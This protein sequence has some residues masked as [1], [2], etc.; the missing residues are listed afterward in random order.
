M[1]ASIPYEVFSE[2]VEK[3]ERQGKEIENVQEAENVQSVWVTGGALSLTCKAWSQLGQKLY[4]RNRVGG[5]DPIRF[6]NHFELYPHLA[7]LARSSSFDLP[8]D[9]HGLPAPEYDWLSLAH[10]PVLVTKLTNLESLK[11]NTHGGDVS[12]LA[13]AASSLKKLTSLEIN[14]KDNIKWRTETASNFQQGFS[15]L[16]HLSI[17]ARLVEL[18]NPQFDIPRRKGKLLSLTS[19]EIGLEV[20]LGP[21]GHQA[22]Q[23]ILSL[24]DPTTLTQITLLHCAASLDNLRW[25]SVTFTNLHFFKLKVDQNQYSIVIETLLELL[26]SLPSLLA[27][28]LHLFGPNPVNTY[29]PGISLT[30]VLRSFSPTL[31]FFVAHQLCFAEDEV[32]SIPF[33]PMGS[34]GS[35]LV[36][37]ALTQ[38]ADGPFVEQVTIWRENSEPSA[39]W[40]RCQT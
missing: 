20:E 8:P 26:P 16:K 4:W 21:N 17:S 37:N 2:I 7:Q 1:V 19:I 32:K 12:R 3:L 22:A 27:F 5:Y 28:S 23:S 24:I 10:L 11:I 39:Q 9:Q 15:S 34:L 38:G 13:R 6:L 14:I 31:K 33:R 25:I 36:T 18:D 35:M 30:S 40:Y 29:E